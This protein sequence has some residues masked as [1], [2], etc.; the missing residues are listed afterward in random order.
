MLRALVTDM[1]KVSTKISSEILPQNFLITEE[2]QFNFRNHV[3][4]VILHIEL[5]SLYLIQRFSLS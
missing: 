1:F 4:F 5:S 3:D 2:G